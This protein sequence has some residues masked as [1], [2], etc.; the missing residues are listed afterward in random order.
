MAVH[1][2]FAQ[3]GVGSMPTVEI[4]TLTA[5]VLLF[6]EVTHPLTDHT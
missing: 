3:E 2:R 6:S 5:P 1:G 4:V